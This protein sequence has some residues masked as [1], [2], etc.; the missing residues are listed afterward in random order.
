MQQYACQSFHMPPHLFKCFEMPQLPR[1]TCRCFFQMLAQT[2]ILAPPGFRWLLM[3]PRV[4]LHGSSY[5]SSIFSFPRLLLHDSCAALSLGCFCGIITHGPS[6]CSPC[7][8][9]FVSV[10][11]SRFAHYTGYFLVPT[12]WCLAMCV[13]SVDAWR[14]V[15]DGWIPFFFTAW[16]ASGWLRA[17]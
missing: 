7:R 11:S 14:W 2:F 15:F 10:D 8:N 5:C 1:D 4:L 9:F 13:F 3:P 17:A 16:L 12:A 6:G